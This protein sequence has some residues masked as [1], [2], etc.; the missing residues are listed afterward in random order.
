MDAPDFR[1]N[2]HGCCC[3]EHSQRGARISEH[4]HGC[5]SGEHCQIDTRMIESNHSCN[6]GEHGRRN[7]MDTDLSCCFQGDSG[8][9]NDSQTCATDYESRYYQLKMEKEKME[10]NYD[11]ERREKEDAER[12]FRQ[13]L[14]EKSL[15]EDKFSSLNQSIQRYD[16]D[17]NL[18]KNENHFLKGQFDS[19]KNAINSRMS[20]AESGTTYSMHL[21]Q[22]FSSSSTATPLSESVDADSYK[23]EVAALANE[24]D[25]LRQII[26]IINQQSQEKASWDERLSE[27]Y[28]FDRKWQT[29]PEVAQLKEENSKLKSKIRELERSRREQESEMEEVTLD[30]EDQSRK[31][32]K[33]IS[34]LEDENHSKSLMVEDLERQLYQLRMEYHE[35]V[36]KWELKLEAEVLMK[37]QVQE[38]VNVLQGIIQNLEAERIEMVTKLEELYSSENDIIQARN[39]LEARFSVEISELQ[40]RLEEEIRT[41][42]ELSQEMTV[43]MNEFVDL[44]NKSKQMEEIYLSEI[45]ALRFNSGFEMGEGAATQNVATGAYLIQ[46]QQTNGSTTTGQRLT[47][48]GGRNVRNDVQSQLNQEIQ[49]REAL[50]KENKE[51]LYKMKN[52]LSNSGEQGNQAIGLNASSYSSDTNEAG[53]GSHHLRKKIRALENKVAE[54]T[55]ECETLQRSAKKGREVEKKN[56]ELLSELDDLS[57]QRDDMLRKQRTLVY[58][59]EKSSSSLH[60]TMDKNRRLIDDMD[61]KSRRIR[62]MEDNFRQERNSLIRSYDREKSSEIRDIE[63]KREDLEKRL[64]DQIR[65]NRRLENKVR[66]LEEEIRYLKQS[67]GQNQLGNMTSW[68]NAVDSNRKGPNV[69]NSTSKMT[70]NSLGLAQETLDLEQ[71]LQ[72]R[73][74]LEDDHLKALEEQRKQM[75][76]EFE[77]EKQKLRQCFEDEKRNLANRFT[78]GSGMGSHG[79]PGNVPVPGMNSTPSSVVVQDTYY[80]QTGQ[81]RQP[82]PQ[83]P[84]IAFPNAQSPVTSQNMFSNQQ[85]SFLDAYHMN[86]TS[87]QEIGNQGSIPN[88]QV[89]QQPNQLHVSFQTPQPHSQQQIPYPNQ[90]SVQGTQSVVQPQVIPGIR[91][92]SQLNPNLASLQQ[93]VQ[94]LNGE[95]KNMEKRLKNMERR[96]A[97]T[98]GNIGAANNSM[99]SMSACDIGSSSENEKEY[100]DNTLGN[101]PDNMQETSRSSTVA[102]N[103]S[104]DGNIDGRLQVTMKKLVEEHRQHSDELRR[105]MKLQKDSFEKE[106]IKMQREYSALLSNIKCLKREVHILKHERETMREK[107]KKERKESQ[108]REERSRDEWTTIRKEYE[109]KIRQEIEKPERTVR[110][111]QRKISISERTL[112]EFE[113]KLRDEVTQIEK[114]YLQERMV[115]EGKLR[116]SENQVRSR[117]EFHYQAKLNTEKEKY[118]N[119]LKDLRKEIKC[120]QAQRREIQLKISSKDASDASVATQKDT[121]YNVVVQNKDFYRRFEKEVETR[122]A[123]EKRRL[124][125]TILDLRK[126]VDELKKEKTDIKSSYREEKLQREEQFERE[127]KRMEERHRY[128]VDE[129]KRTNDMLEDNN[130]KLISM[131]GGVSER[132]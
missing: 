110:E 74:R 113:I 13:E 29:D 10:R 69:S 85:H 2:G 125:D 62:D 56:R 7:M 43:L 11:R 75:R 33:D 64:D 19:L 27:K 14:E 124:D 95:K 61:S 130:I 100:M 118:E 38:E 93:E 37:T 79:M 99:M 32:K 107:L 48:S 28:T 34:R 53:G 51:L 114:K 111:L 50:E 101:H 36:Q 98:S 70:T 106:K 105:Q 121:S 108:M 117:L 52:I 16:D 84:S 103:Y 102:M 88:Y 26:E 123:Q 97:S 15:I 115:L 18:L 8:M 71:L 54:L 112:K 65:E 83:N 20:A 4:S 82:M 128:D 6:C 96:M 22:E 42:V 60:D 129:L 127:K 67:N 126:E 76:E 66:D 25:V 92:D 73:K 91:P 45:E 5:S 9:H 132:N 68:S 49:K 131:Q 1:E 59:V 94:R 80:T 23:H 78:A 81:T 86:Q 72:E 35:E 55:E 39:D 41:K 17:L 109:M 12:K 58:E 104:S 77:M 120:L 87:P 63:R 40:A 119:T 24:N 90:Y 31:T 3:G 122:F 57:T 21:D 44:R 116:E 30:M 47:Q 89:P 46:Q